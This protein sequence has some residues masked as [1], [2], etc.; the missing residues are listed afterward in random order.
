MAIADEVRCGGAAAQRGREQAAFSSGRAAAQR[1]ER[2]ARQS[3]RVRGP[4]LEALDVAADAAAP[5]A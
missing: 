4:E 1:L 3:P 2:G 5:R